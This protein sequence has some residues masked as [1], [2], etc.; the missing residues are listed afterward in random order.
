LEDAGAEL[1]AMSD[2]AQRG[3]TVVTEL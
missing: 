2:F 3:V 1:A